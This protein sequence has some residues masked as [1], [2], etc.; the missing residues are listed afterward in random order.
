[1]PAPVIDTDL[2]LAMIICVSVALKLIFT[3]GNRT[4]LFCGESRWDSAAQE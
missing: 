4:G 3:A 1:M 2:P